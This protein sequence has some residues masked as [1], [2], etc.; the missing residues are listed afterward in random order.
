M[1]DKLIVGLL[2]DAAATSYKRKPIIPF[3]QRKA[4]LEALECVDIVV[5][6]GRDETRLLDVIQPDIIVKGRHAKLGKD[7]HYIE[8]W[9]KRNERTLIY[10][11]YIEE[12]STTKIIKKIH[13]QK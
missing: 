1:G 11:P 4:I 2:T 8:D 6:K 13:D 3:K 10:L 7:A 9:I 5:S 12:Q